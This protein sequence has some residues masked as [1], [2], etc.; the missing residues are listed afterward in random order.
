MKDSTRTR[1][2]VLPQWLQR[3]FSNCPARKNAPVVVYRKDGKVLS[4]G[5]HNVGVRK[6]FFTSDK[7]D[8][9]P[10]LTELDAKLSDVAQRLRRTVGTL[11]RKQRV[12]AC[13]V[14]AHLEVRQDAT[15]KVIRTMW[16]SSMPVIV[17]YLQNTKTASAWLG[18]PDIPS[19]SDLAHIWDGCTKMI[20]RYGSSNASRPIDLKKMIEF[21]ILNLLGI[22]KLIRND[23]Q[24]SHED[25]TAIGWWMRN[26]HSSR[27][28]EDSVRYNRSK[29]LLEGA[30]A[31]SRVT[32]YNSFMWRVFRPVEDVVLG[33]SMVFHDVTDSSLGQNFL[34]NPWRHAAT[35]LPLGPRC[36]LIGHQRKNRPP[37]PTAELLKDL[38]VRTSSE[39]FIARTAKPDYETLVQRIGSY[40]KF[41]STDDWRIVV[42]EC[43]KY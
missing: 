30:E 5:T 8:A 18:R 40:R 27:Y 39:F 24:K 29:Q 33:D 1:Q 12:E 13:Q 23:M 25:K 7:F 6:G 34:H 26:L 14:V 15:E 38:A 32:G 41:A 9:D 16:N 35:Y 4:T 11:A 20:F 19:A 43:L 10:K 42:E 22:K 21:T 36:V 37:L 28:L 17:R 31:K 3:S 2:H